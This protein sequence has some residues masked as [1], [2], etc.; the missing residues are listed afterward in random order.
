MK[1]NSA[2][3]LEI[4]DALR[5]IREIVSDG[6]LIISNHAKERMRERGYSIHDVEY[7][8]L[9]GDITKKEF[10]EKTSNWKYTVKG[11]DL[12]GDDGGVALAI[13]RR[14]SSIVITVL[15]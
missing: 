12:D 10:N 4:K 1:F 14:M 7:I 9:H 8:L 6:T 13:I 15:G 11:K 2:D 3:E 5:I